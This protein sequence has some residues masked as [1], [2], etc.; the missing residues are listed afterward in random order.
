MLCKETLFKAHIFLALA[1]LTISSTINQAYSAEALS[2]S[3]NV[4]EESYNA[5]EYVR[6]NGIIKDEFNNPVSSASISIQVNKPSGEILHLGLAYSNQDGTFT[7]EFRVPSDAEEGT[8]VIHLTAS[9]QGYSDATT[10]ISCIVVSEFNGVIAI[11]LSLTV[12]LALTTIFKKK[13]KP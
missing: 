12:L 7:H 8:Y 6:I 1:L 11:F 13:S 9:K 10:Q 2:I 4:S 5:G 3:A